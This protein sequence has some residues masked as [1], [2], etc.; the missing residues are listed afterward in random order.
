LNNRV[1]NQFDVYVRDTA[2]DTDDGT[3]GG[4]AI[5]VSQVSDATN[6]LSLAPAFLLGSA[7][8]WTLAL[9]NQSLAVAP[10]HDTYTGQSFDLTGN[11]GRFIAIK[12]DS[13][14]GDTGGVGLGKIRIEGIPE[15]RAALLGA[16]GL[17]AL[18]RRRR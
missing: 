9:S 3:V 11:T 8:P 18:L 10:N 4:A 1:I 5:N 13:Y 12:A 2:A 16:L 15:P 17:F 7:D 14:H 6:A